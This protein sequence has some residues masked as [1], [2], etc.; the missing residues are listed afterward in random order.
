MKMDIFGTLCHKKQTKIWALLS[1]L[2]L[3]VV[4]SVS[5]EARG[6]SDSDGTKTIRY[7]IWGDS[8]K[9]VI[10]EMIAAFEQENPGVQ[11]D[12]QVVPYT[13]YWPK[14]RTSLSAGT[15]W[16]VFWINAPYFPVYENYG[17][18]SDLSDEYRKAGV[19]FDKFPKAIVEMYQIDGRPYTLPWFF[20]SVVFYYNK[21]RFDEAGLKYPNADWTLDDVQVAA[22]QLRNKAAKQW[23]IYLDISSEIVWGILLSNGGQIF[24]EDRMSL[25]YTQPKSLE[26]W[27]KFYRLFEQ[28]L[29]PAPSIIKAGGGISA[30]RSMLASGAIA[31]LNAGSWAYSDLRGQMGENLGVSLLP[32][33]KAGQKSTTILHGLGHVAYTKSKHLEA[34]K[35]FALYMTSPKAQEILARANSITPTYQPATD[36]WVKSFDYPETGAILSGTQ[37]AYPYQIVKPGGLEW[38]T[39]ATEI[40][41]DTFNGNIPFAE[42]MQRAVEEADRII[43]G[44]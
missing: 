30:M 14:L 27:Q 31:M 5:L 11:V 15:A 17:V 22:E 9:Q 23:G 13:D 10:N 8:H 29:S 12:L 19:D 36:L 6:S 16:D 2:G 40:L 38:D 42:G 25:A 35:K 3:F 26:V 7:G 43:Q 33:A 1:L 20:N 21:A 44:N 41:E 32:A 4:L 18:I 37:G 34:A 24:T 28:D 39:R